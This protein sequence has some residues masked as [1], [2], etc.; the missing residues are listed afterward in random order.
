V[1]ISS[2]RDE[3]R[4]YFEAHPELA[5]VQEHWYIFQFFKPYY[6][7]WGIEGTARLCGW[8]E[9]E[10]RKFFL[11]LRHVKTRGARQ[12]VWRKLAEY[13]RE[14]EQRRLVAMTLME[15]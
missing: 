12:Q 8:K 11:S 14:R 6:E 10:V 2:Q 9:R 1:P 15:D 4:A 7:G 5:P 13:A 3:V